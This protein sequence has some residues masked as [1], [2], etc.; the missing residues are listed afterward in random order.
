MEHSSHGALA[1]SAIKA[2]KKHNQKWLSSSICTAWPILKWLFRTPELLL[3][4]LETA[5]SSSP[6]VKPWVRRG[7]DGMEKR[8]T[9]AESI[10]M[11]PSTM[12]MYRH[13]SN[14]LCGYVSTTDGRRVTFPLGKADNVLGLLIVLRTFPQLS[15]R[16]RAV[17]RH[18]TRCPCGGTTRASCTNYASSVL[19]H[20]PANHQHPSG[21][22]ATFGLTKKHW[23][24]NPCQLVHAVV[25]C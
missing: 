21:R 8:I 18:V 3:L 9:K 2:M 12:D 17:H 16:S 19:D 20:I 24:Y 25:I 13:G 1:T 14:A 6:S 23:T 5:I 7:S 10:V 4:I 22:N 11:E 15:K